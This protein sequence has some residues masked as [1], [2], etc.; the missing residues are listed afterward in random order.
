MSLA[1]RRELLDLAENLG[2]PVFEDDPYG[3]LRYRGEPIPTLKRLAGDSPFVVY[4]SS[5]SK[6]LAP[7]VRVA[8]TVA[9]AEIVRAMVLTRQGEDLCTSTVTQALVAEYCRRGLLEKHLVK[10]I[11]H[12]AAKC[13]AMQR[14]L[15]AHL[16]PGAAEWLRPEGGYF[17]WLTL[18]GRDSREVFERAV[19]EGV[20]FV[21][22]PAFYPGPEEQIGDAVTG[23][24]HARLAFTFAN[25]ESIDEGCRRFASALG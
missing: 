1:R 3:R 5:F 12:Y 24:P 16:P 17:Y 19:A 20:A 14:S 11:A 2:V 4:A 9:D 15:T 10:M 8:W 25:E 18:P 7:G 22:G 6:V 21:P 13:S 23:D